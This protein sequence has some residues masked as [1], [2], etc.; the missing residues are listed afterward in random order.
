MNNLE[1]LG[2]N[3]GGWII[4]KDI[5]LNNNSIV[6]SGG[7]GEDISFDLII[8]DKYNSKLYLIDP[9]ERSYIHYNEI[10][11][12]Y[13]NNNFIFSGDIQRDYLNKIIKLKP[14]F[15]NINYVNYGIWDEDT[16][17]KF[18]KPINNKYVSHSIIENMCSKEYIN[19][20]TKT[21]KQ[22]ME[23]YN[24]TKIDLLKLDIEGAEIKVINKMLDDNIYPD[25]LLIEFDLLLKRKD[26]NNT[27]QKLVNRLLNNYTILIN[28][29][30][31]ITF[32][33]NSVG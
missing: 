14:N 33:S 11:K 6:Y 8:S 10:I 12:G 4:P 23:M 2:T 31:N 25:Y 1:K 28:D 19:I 7:V 15:Y 16:E 24:H 27:T 13:N 20:K 30:Y 17:L 29:N 26:H 21:I 9:T 5:K 32:K 18:Y 3:Y 22:I